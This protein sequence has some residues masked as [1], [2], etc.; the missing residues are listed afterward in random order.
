MYSK[1]ITAR[2]HKVA[3]EIRRLTQD[4]FVKGFDCGDNALDS[5][6]KRHAWANQEQNLIGVTYVAVE[7]SHPSSIVGYY[8]MATGDLPRDSLPAD[9]V[10]TL[11]RYQNLPVALLARLAVDRR[12]Q[13]SGLGKN[14]LR[15]AF[16]TV[17][18]LSRQV[19]CRFLIVDAYS[20]AVEWYSKYGFIAVA[21][22]SSG[23]MQTMF[24]D[25]RTLQ[26]ATL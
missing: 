10:K 5:Y 22:I 14:L 20:T 9:L 24:V 6:L 23:G 25:V 16:G 1:R 12:F 7:D 11:P 13:G 18:T 3:L 21:G 8:T 26:A 19:G 17:L 15:H 4:D 2:S